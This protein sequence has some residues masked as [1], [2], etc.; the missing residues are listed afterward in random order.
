MP[1]PVITPRLTPMLRDRL[2]KALPPPVAQDT[3]RDLDSLLHSLRNVA[4]RIHDRPLPDPDTCGVMGQHYLALVEPVPGAQAGPF[5][6]QEARTVRMLQYMHEVEMTDAGGSIS[7]STAIAG[8]LP[9]LRL[10]AHLVRELRRE[11]GLLPH[12]FA[13]LPFWRE[14]AVHHLAVRVLRA[15]AECRLQPTDVR[16]FNVQQMPPVPGEHDGGVRLQVAAWNS[17]TAPPLL[18]AHRTG[19]DAWDPSDPLE[20][21]GL[22][23]ANAPIVLD[24]TGTG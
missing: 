19:P 24:W 18:P 13:P 22:D 14:L 21:G 6:A 10:H 11:M 3:L 5:T 15:S 17:A 2:E 8:R 7:P 16:L 4:P 20:A 23:L 9:Q 12:P 1:S